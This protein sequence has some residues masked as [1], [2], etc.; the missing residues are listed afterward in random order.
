MVQTLHPEDLQTS[1]GTVPKSLLLG[2]TLRLGALMVPG[3]YTL[4]VIAAD[5]GHSG[6]DRAVQWIDFEV[7]A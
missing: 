7:L 3:T 4:E 1:T 5:A 6:S 2:G